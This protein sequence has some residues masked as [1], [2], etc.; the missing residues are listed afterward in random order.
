[1]DD[2]NPVEH[3]WYPHPPCLIPLFVGHG[4]SY[5]GLIQH[6][7]CERK[8]TFA[9]YFLEHGFVSE[10]ARNADQ[11]I[12]LMV[13]KMILTKDG[14]TTD[15]LDFCKQVNYT[16]YEALDEFTLEYGDNPEKFNH[17]PFFTRHLPFKYLK[18]LLDYYGDFPSSIYI[19][20]HESIVKQA[21]IFEI[22]PRAKL[23]EVEN[24][25]V[26]LSSFEG[27]QEKFYKFLELGQFK[28]AW[29]ML[30]TPGW[31]LKDLAQSL[32]ELADKAGEPALTL[33]AENW[34]F[35]WKQSTFVNGNL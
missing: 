2:S 5:K 22:A 8:Q 31:L 32:L 23:S 33:V 9:E 19:L 34:I 11:F 13:L 12:T 14:L 26:W 3:Y 28:E 17:L 25:P 18:D 6:F 16:Q 15:I 35:G 1:M 10:I 24:L 4:A 21:S 30:N 27:N 29:F 7:F 20:N